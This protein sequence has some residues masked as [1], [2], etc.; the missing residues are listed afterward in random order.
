MVVGSLACDVRLLST[1]FTRT[2]GGII[3]SVEVPPAV[4]ERWVAE[5]IVVVPDVT[6]P[7]PARVRAAKRRR[8]AIP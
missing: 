8:K 4:W 6:P 2:A 1:G 3:S 5:G 7:R